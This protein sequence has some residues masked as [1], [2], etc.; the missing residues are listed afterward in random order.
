[1][2]LSFPHHYWYGVGMLKVPAVIYN[3]FCSRYSSQCV[4][5][6]SSEVHTIERRSVDAVIDASVYGYCVAHDL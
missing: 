1:M 3:P 4:G 5:L 6:A 2:C